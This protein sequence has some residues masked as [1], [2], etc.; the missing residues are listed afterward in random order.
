VRTRLGSGRLCIHFNAVVT[1]E[2][3]A[4]L[5]LITMVLER[6][7]LKTLVGLDSAHGIGASHTQERGGPDGAGALP[8]VPGTGTCVPQ[9]KH[10]LEATRPHLELHLA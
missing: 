6:I 3:L 1:W 2:T 4:A 10:Y 9:K 5:Y 8:A 7:G